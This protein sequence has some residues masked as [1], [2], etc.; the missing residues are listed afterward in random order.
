MVQDRLLW[1]AEDWPESLVTIATHFNDNDNKS[2][3]GG[4]SDQGYGYASQVHLNTADN[5]LQLVSVFLE[6]NNFFLW[7]F[8]RG[9]CRLQST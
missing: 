7:V 2:T 4:S 5:V 1:L 8:A 3:E 6:C 9:K